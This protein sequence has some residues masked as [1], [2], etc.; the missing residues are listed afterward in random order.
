MNNDLAAL[1]GSRICHDLISP[2]GAIGNGVELLTMTN[3]QP[4][5]E[6]ALISESVDSAN[7]RIRFFRI[8]FGAAS[9]DQLIGEGE[10]KTILAAVTKG[11]RLRYHWH[12]A[13]D[14]PRQMV[15]CAF[16]MML[17]C[18]TALPL[19]G[20]IHI[21]QLGTMW[22]FTA[23]SE[24][25]KLDS[26]LWDSLTDCDDTTQHGAAHVQFALLPVALDDCDRA[27][28][29]EFTETQIKGRF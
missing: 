28:H 8:A 17:C 6:M 9:P 21:R 2:I 13:G 14:H 4:G 16:L 22:D 10:I 1:V 25:I 11:G 26:A 12:P 27:A 29:F 20:D 5:E 19:G 23:Q 7:A 3:G 15:R 18:E 24:R